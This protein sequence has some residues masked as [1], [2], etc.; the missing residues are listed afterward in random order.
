MSFNKSLVSSNSND[1]TTPQYLF[2]ELNHEFMFTV[3]AASTDENALLE[4]HWTKKEDGLAQNW[5][6]ERVW[7]NPPYGNELRQWV[8]KA[9]ESKGLSVLLVPARTD[10]KYWHEYIFPHAAEIRF[11]RGRLHFSDSK[12]ASPFPSAIIVF[13]GRSKM[14]NDDTIE[15]RRKND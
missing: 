3:D 13:D 10:T 11:L 15:N 9:R 5:D 6:C 8:K 2:D 1:W 14:K 7:C 4:K 12:N